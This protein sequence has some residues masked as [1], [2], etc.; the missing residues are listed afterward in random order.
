[1]KL[2]EFIKEGIIV[3]GEFKTFDF[4]TTDRS[5]PFLGF[6]EN[7]KYKNQISPYMRCVICNEECREELPESVQGIAIVNNPKE[8]WY[9]LYNKY[10]ETVRRTAKKKNTTI[11]EE[12]VIHPTCIIAKENVVIGNHVRIDEFAVVKENVVIED[13]CHIHAGVIIGGDGFNFFCSGESDVLKLIGLGKTVIETGVELFPY[14]H[15]ANG[16]L[17]EEE[18]RIGS[19]SKLDAYI[20]VAHGVRMGKR[21]MIAA[22]AQLGGNCN[23]GN[24]V[25]IGVNATVSNRIHIGDRA[26]VSLGAVVTKHIPNDMRVSGN[27]A[28]EHQIFLSNLKKFLEKD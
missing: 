21:V 6:L 10:A 16:T 5:I 4:C 14:V 8:T 11:G 15:I 9:C 3:D 22:G 23:I 24:D 7:K 13:G 27:F 18:T 19:H 20:H 26:K 1:M 2:S 12:C 25:W 28:I 17:P